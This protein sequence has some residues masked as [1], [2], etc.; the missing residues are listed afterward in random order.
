MRRIITNWRSRHGHRPA[1]TGNPGGTPG[2]PH[3][4]PAPRPG[5]AARTPAAGEDTGAGKGDGGRLASAL[6]TNPLFTKYTWLSA[7]CISNNYGLEVKVTD[8]K[9]FQQQ[10]FE[11]QQQQRFEQ[12]QKEKI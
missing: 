9:E 5:T 6:I 3:L 11:Q 8:W 10:R 1:T 2:K 7:L 4:D 12:Q